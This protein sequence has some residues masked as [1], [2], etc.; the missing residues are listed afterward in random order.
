M[1]SGINAK[2]KLKNMQPLRDLILIK[3]EDAVKETKT[4]S[5]LVLLSTD[6][7]RFQINDQESM[8]QELIKKPK[9][10]K[11]EVIEVGNS[12]QYFQKTDVVIYKK[13]TESSD[14]EYDGSICVFVNEKDILVKCTMQGFSVHPDFVLVKITKESREALY[15]KKI[16]R[17]DG[18]EVLLFIGGD[19]GPDDAD[20]NSIFVGSG[21]IVAVGKNA[22]DLKCG[23]VALISYLCD[24][25]DS[26]IVGYEGE[27]KLIAVKAVTTRHKEKRIAY[28][29]RRPVLDSKGNP[30]YKNGKAQTYSK[31]TIIFEKGDYDELSSLYG[32]VRGDEL[33]TISPYC[34]LEH[35]E[36]KVMKVG[37]GGVIF[38]EDEK[39]IT[40]KILSVSQETKELIGVEVGSIV[41]GDDYD[42]FTLQFGDKKI[43]AV[44][45][46][47]ILYLL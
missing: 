25:D 4:A 1:A 21:E 28:A 19:K 31:D 38:E 41:I 13:N 37:G 44:N 35:K 7:N 33:I 40:R 12:A 6:N 26:I 32:A 10:N 22:K 30:V 39:I 36:T 8:L 2:T 27:D 42:F 23:D 11:G 5:G 14:I 34:F 47:D 29:S 43:S 16:K 18:E 9:T 46:I 20:S 17:H 15:N 24:N 3:Q 45:D